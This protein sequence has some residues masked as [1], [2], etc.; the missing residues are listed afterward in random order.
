MSEQTEEIVYLTI[1]EWKEQYGEPKMACDIFGRI[2]GTFP[3]EP[4]FCE[5][6][7]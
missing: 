2:L 5:G 1:E 6:E 7:E 4:D 3:T